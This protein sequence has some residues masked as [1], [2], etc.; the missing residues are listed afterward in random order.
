MD[1][2]QEIMPV[3]EV[4]PEVVRDPAAGVVVE[5]HDLLSIRVVHNR[6]TGAI[7]LS[8]VDYIMEV[9]TRHGIEGTRRV[10][11]TRDDLKTGV[12]ASVGDEGAIPERLQLQGGTNWAAQNTRLDMQPVVR[13]AS[14]IPAVA[15]S[16]IFRQA[17]EYAGEPR[18]LCYLPEHDKEEGVMR[19]RAQA[20]SDWASETDR[21]SVSGGV[22]R[23]FGQTVDC[24]SKKQPTTAEHS[25]EAEIVANH[26][27]H[28]RVRRLENFVDTSIVMNSL[29]KRGNPST[30]LIHNQ[31][32]NTWSR[33]T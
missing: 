28:K 14:S 21:I 15:G 33:I 23:I 6:K 3:T 22:I 4:K 10:P 27:V 13:F 17:L 5:I 31:S 30:S 26:A 11:Y 20:D 18:A 12:V 7:F 29:S 8:Q 24:L 25:T 1:E 16:K 9:R 2:L 32:T 19:F